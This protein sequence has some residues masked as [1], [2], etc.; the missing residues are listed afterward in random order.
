[1]SISSLAARRNILEVAVGFLYNG[2]RLR[3]YNGTQP[4]ETQAVPYFGTRF[5]AFRV[6][7]RRRISHAQDT[8]S[9]FARSRHNVGCRPR[10]SGD[11]HFGW[12]MH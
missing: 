5:A 8:Q 7:L 10:V 11:R 9:C 4:L 3:H 12:P 2:S 6:D 1:M